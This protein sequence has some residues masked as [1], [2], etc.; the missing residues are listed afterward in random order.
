MCFSRIVLLLF[1]ILNRQS[2]AAIIIY[3][4][5]SSLAI[6]ISFKNIFLPFSYTVS[7]NSIFSCINSKNFGLNLE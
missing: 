4:K 5:V 6:S 2:F 1:V 3:S 7:I